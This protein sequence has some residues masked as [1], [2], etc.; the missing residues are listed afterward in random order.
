[1]ARW[2]QEYEHHQLGVVTSKACASE[3]R[4][5]SNR[6]MRRMILNLSVLL[7][8]VCLWAQQSS[9][10]RTEKVAI[11]RAK[12]V[13]ASSFDR[14][15]PNVSLEFFLKYES[16]GAPIKW[17][18]SDCREQIGS[19]APDQ[20]HG[21]PMC[22]EADFEFKEQ[23]AVT[24]LVSVGTFNRGPSGVP[25]LISV[26]ITES[27]TI[28]PVRH[29]SDLPVELHRPAPRPP[30][31]LPV[32]VGALSAVPNAARAFEEV[33]EAVKSGVGQRFVLGEGLHGIVHNPRS[34]RFT[35]LPLVAPQSSG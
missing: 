10:N 13:I 11:Q 27:G 1:M 2:V 33:S 8:T 20:E 3:S 21:P 35:I 32:P 29:L 28:R 18:V 14:S 31:D 5:V 4:V 22:V 23:T 19:P 25:A 26:T 24:V 15:L 16:G 12:S 6:G 30:R 7:L 9:V 17:G 34:N